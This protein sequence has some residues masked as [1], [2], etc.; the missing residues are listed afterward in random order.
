MNGPAALH[1]V[2]KRH[3]AGGEAPRQL[4]VREGKRGAAWRPTHPH[5]MGTIAERRA[6]LERAY[7][8]GADAPKSQAPIDVGGKSLSQRKEDLE[9]FH[10]AM[11]QFSKLSLSL[12]FDLEGAM[13]KFGTDVQVRPCL[14]AARAC[15][16]QHS[17]DPP[18]M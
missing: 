13:S 16:L 3:K 6:A 11:Q 2:H 18:P 1:L 5:P 4:C 7:A 17:R 12:D 9:G 14:V 8:G 10:Q 15:G